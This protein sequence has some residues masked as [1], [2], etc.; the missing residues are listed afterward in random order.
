MAFVMGIVTMVRVGRATP[1]KIA[2][3][4]INDAIPMLKGQM[5]QSQLPAP[6]VSAAE[7][8]S[9]LKRLGELEE[10]VNVLS[11]KP[12]EMA[13]EK[14]E[15]LNAAV[16]RVDALEAELA[17]TKK[18]TSSITFLFKISNFGRSICK[19]II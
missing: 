17:A 9:V 7:F 15:M 19:D 13:P 2:N 5:H 3:A 11:T 1:R 14:E 18:V 16:M 8:S 4:D 6:T 10:K 12:A